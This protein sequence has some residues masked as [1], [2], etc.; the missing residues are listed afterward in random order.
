MY[1]FLNRRQ[2]AEDVGRETA[3]A[4]LAVYQPFN[5]P[6]ESQGELV[7]EDR[8]SSQWEQ[9]RIIQHEEESWHKSV[10]KRE[11]GDERERVWLDEMVLDPRIA[12]RMRKFVLDME[13][14][15]RAKRIG[16]ERYSDGWFKSFWPKTEEKKNNLWEG[17]EED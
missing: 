13:A 15:E 14:E 3:A 8:Q 11:D 5:S 9:Q 6:G 2:V 10:Q 16:S 4:V 1:R 7:S 12:E 17:L